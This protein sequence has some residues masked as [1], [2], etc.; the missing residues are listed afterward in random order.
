MWITEFSPVGSSVDSSQLQNADA[1]VLLEVRDHDLVAF[2]EPRDDF[3]VVDARDAEPG[4][5]P[6][7]AVAV[8]DVNLLLAAGDAG[9]AVELQAVGGGAGLDLHVDAQVVAQ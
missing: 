5:S 7:G 3:D 2:G 6:L 9:A 4:E 1:A 8:D